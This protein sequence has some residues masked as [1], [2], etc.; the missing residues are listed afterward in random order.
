MLCDILGCATILYN[1]DH[2]LPN[3]GPLQKKF[4]R[5]MV[6]QRCVLSG[7]NLNVFSLYFT[8]HAQTVL[9][10]LLKFVHA[11]V[12]CS[13]CDQQIQFLSTTAFFL[14]LL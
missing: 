10:F 1:R 6:S 13:F 4:V 5:H 14:K 9:F 2:E 7:C 12:H 11:W 3:V 8:E